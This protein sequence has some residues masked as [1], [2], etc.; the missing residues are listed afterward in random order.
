V[1]NVESGQRLRQARFYVVVPQQMLEGVVQRCLFVYVVD[2]DLGFVLVNIA[3]IVAN[4][5][6]P[7][8]HLRVFDL[9]SVLAHNC[10]LE[11]LNRLHI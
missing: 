7:Q 10:V 1:R 6:F 2:V 9:K 11:Q 3:G 4:V 8:N 5:N